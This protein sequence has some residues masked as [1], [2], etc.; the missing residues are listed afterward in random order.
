MNI[1]FRAVNTFVSQKLK[2]SIVQNNAKLAK[3]SNQIS[4]GQIADNYT[5]IVGITSIEGFLNNKFQVATLDSKIRNNKDL[6]AKFNETERVLNSFTDL[7][8]RSLKL[9]YQMRDPTV[10]DSLQAEP[11]IKTLL[12]EIKVLLNSSFQGQKIFAGFATGLSDVVGDIANVSNIVAS[13]P[14][15]NYYLGDYGKLN[16]QISNERSVAY[17]VTAADIAFQNLIGAHHFMLD[18][19]TSRALDTLNDAKKQIG[20][21]ITM[22]GVYD[23]AVSSQISIDEAKMGQLNLAISEVEDI[24]VVQKYLELTYLQTHLKASFSVANQLKDMSLVNYLR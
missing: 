21:L 1:E 11:L 10:G 20:S 8:R 18:G 5:D 4:S 15:A 17:G 13:M 2:E 9:L 16:N 6:I 19:D 3:V 22:I 14:S 24:D 7:T 23:N 12:D